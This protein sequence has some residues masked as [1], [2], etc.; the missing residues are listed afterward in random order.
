VTF[1]FLIIPPLTAHL[2]ARSMRQFALIASILGGTTSFVGF[3]LAYRWDL[4]V[5]PTD[6][7]LLGF[8]YAL[9]FLV[10]R[11]AT[12]AGRVRLASVERGA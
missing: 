7:V 4:P 6:V 8:I 3:A 10:K 12:L 1:G 2:V 11:L 9:V 5:G